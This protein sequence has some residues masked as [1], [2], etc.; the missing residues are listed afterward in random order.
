MM[1]AFTHFSLENPSTTIRL[2]RIHKDLQGG[3]L[4][5]EIRDVDVKSATYFA[6][7]YVW[8][9]EPAYYKILLNGL[10]FWIRLNLWTFLTYAQEHFPES[11]L[12]V[13]AL[14]INQND[15][16][17]KSIQVAMMDKTFSRAKKVIAWVYSPTIPSTAQ[18][19]NTCSAEALAEVITSQ[20][21][22]MKG[23]DHEIVGSALARLI[24]LQYW[25]R[26]WVVQELELASEAEILWDFQMISWTSLKG[27]MRSIL[28]ESSSLDDTDSRAFNVELCL[29][30]YD[31]DLARLPFMAFLNT[32]PRNLKMTIQS[33]S[34]SC[35]VIDLVFRFQNHQCT[36]L[37]DRVYAFLGLTS[38]REDFVVDY[39]EP[40]LA[41]FLRVV[42]IA[43]HIPTDGQ[44]NNLWSLLIGEA[45]YGALSFPGLVLAGSDCLCVPL[46]G[47]QFCLALRPLQRHVKFSGKARNIFADKKHV[48][49]EIWDPYRMKQYFSGAGT[50]LRS[51][52]HLPGVFPWIRDTSLSSNRVLRTD[53]FIFHPGSENIFL[54]SKSYDSWFDNMKFPIPRQTVYSI[55]RW[56]HGVKL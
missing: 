14:C 56:I 8:G 43:E 55:V 3:L 18:D 7:S 10:D 5:C 39:T 45:T 34:R 1:P 52:F 13:D 54:A 41:L 29:K 25:S 46:P 28:Q 42:F 47:S 9:T 6:L 40:S 30:R 36:I 31:I 11:D 2:L 26:A 48:N 44:L 49:I 35:D 23:L 4:S 53:S 16:D 24:I 33:E 27:F 20:D 22:N 17:E 12:W 19:L 15:L 38:K 32:A 51:N 50:P 37:Q 21:Q